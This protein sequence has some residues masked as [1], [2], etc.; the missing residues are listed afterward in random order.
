MSKKPVNSGLKR[1]NAAL[2]A[3]PATL[4]HTHKPRPFAVSA[5]TGGAYLFGEVRLG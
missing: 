2:E 4:M 3:F 1:L 5:S